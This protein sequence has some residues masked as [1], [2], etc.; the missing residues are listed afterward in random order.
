MQS[1]S[2]ILIELWSLIKQLFVKPA[3]TEAPPSAADAAALEEQNLRDYYNNANDPCVS[4][5]VFYLRV[6]V[7]HWD[8]EEALHD[9]KHNSR[10]FLYNKHYEFTEIYKACKAPAVTYNAFYN[11][12]ALRHWPVMEALMTPNKQ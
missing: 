10:I 12:V 8:M 3:K 11:R 4:F 6:A 2:H 1:I 5:R 7:F 9:D